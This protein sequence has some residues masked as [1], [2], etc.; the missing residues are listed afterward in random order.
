MLL[1]LRHC[2][3]WNA[4]SR[5]QT[6]GNETQHLFLHIHIHSLSHSKSPTTQFTTINSKKTK[7]VTNP[8]GSGKKLRRNLVEIFI[9]CFWMF[10][11]MVHFPM[12]SHSCFFTVLP[13]SRCLHINHVWYH[14]IVT[15]SYVTTENKYSCPFSTITLLTMA[16]HTRDY[17]W[18]YACTTQLQQILLY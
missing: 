12:F 13:D 16:H 14:I 11:Y 4:G 17:R 8:F 15:C 1:C 5:H 2:P 9:N 6:L 10:C 3:S 18:I 7:K